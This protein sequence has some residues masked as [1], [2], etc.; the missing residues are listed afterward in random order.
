MVRVPPSGSVVVSV[1]ATGLDV[2]TS[3]VVMVLWI[4][5]ELGAGFEDVAV[6]PVSIE[7][8]TRVV[9]DL[10]GR[11]V[12]SVNAQRRVRR[13]ADVWDGEAQKGEMDV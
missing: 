2:A 8:K 7:Q 9:H 4:F 11:V 12:T 13:D 1:C 6:F 10:E 3:P 5:G